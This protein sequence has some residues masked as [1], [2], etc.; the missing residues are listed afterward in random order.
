LEEGERFGR[1]KEE[2]GER[3]GR[4]KKLEE[5]EIWEKEEIGGRREIW[6]GG[7]ELKEGEGLEGGESWNSCRDE[8]GM[9]KVLEE[10]E[11]FGREKKLEEGERFGRGKKVEEGERF[12]SEK[13]LKEREG[14]REMELR[15]VNW[16]REKLRIEKELE[17]IIIN[18][19]RF[20]S[21]ELLPFFLS[22]HIV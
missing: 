7:K 6:G 1:E 3:F 16:G 19:N 9:E 20:L 10:G 2:E 17:D 18:L 12:V 8:L 14:G 13:E 4:G 15:E 21:R 5:G 11:R 22:V